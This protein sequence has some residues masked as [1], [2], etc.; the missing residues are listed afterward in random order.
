[1]IARTTA[2]VLLL[3]LSVGLT[4]C[5]YGSSRSTESGVLV[6]SR[7][8]ER[9][10]PG[11]TTVDWVRATLGEPSRRS[12]YADG[13][14]LWVYTYSRHEESSGSFLIIIGGKDESEEHEST[15]IEFADGVVSEAWQ[16]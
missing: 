2:S 1:M 16:E 9:I 12:T 11:E 5:I 15:F 8:F 13:K 4:G 3:S 10:V 14:E 6:G 7:T